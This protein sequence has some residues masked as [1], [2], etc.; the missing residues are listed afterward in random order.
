MNRLLLSWL[1]LALPAWATT[2]PQQPA[3][4]GDAGQTQAAAAAPARDPPTPAQVLAIPPALKALLRQQVSAP[5]A[6]REERLQRLAAM[7]FDARG[8]GLQYDASATTTLDETWQ[9]RRANCL[10]FTLLF[11]TLAR[12]AG[13]QAQVQEVDQVVSWVED[14]GVAYNVGHVNAR[15]SFN[16]RHGTVD[17]DSTVLYG[18]GGPRPISDA[19]ALAH[20]YN[21]RGAAWMDAGD[22]DSARR[23]Y[24]AALQQDP[25]FAAAW[26]NLGVLEARL[27]NRAQARTHFERALQLAPRNAAALTNASGLLHTLGQ[28]RQAA[29]LQ[30][31]LQRVRRSD[32][33]VQ[34]LL[35]AQ[36][37][38]SGQLATAIGYYRRAVRLYDGAHQFHFG[39]ARAYLLSGQL[40]AADSELQRAQALAG[41]PLQARY[42]AKRESLQRWRRQQ[43]ATATGTPRAP[44]QRAW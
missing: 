27:G 35:G 6:S 2:A 12:E 43:A 14:A 13:L 19:R 7:I 1:L 26:N 9:Q 23:H 42:Q 44:L 36:A 10:A 33:F 16:G 20:F 25:G 32:P 18:R 38:R 4:V 29:V 37:E 41:A 40:R 28:S 3:A 30:Q 21:N 24:Q 34:Y 31:R 8:M 39:L 15:V 5:T 17:L 22:T 11:V